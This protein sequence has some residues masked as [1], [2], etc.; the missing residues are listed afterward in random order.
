MCSGET[1]AVPP[2]L[3]PAPPSAPA[4]RFAALRVPDVRTYLV[5]GALAMMADNIELRS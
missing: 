1:P 4:P 3:P 5:G 2:A